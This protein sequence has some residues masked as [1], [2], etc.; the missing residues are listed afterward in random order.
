MR[1]EGRLTQAE[2]RKLGRQI[3]AAL[4]ADRIQ[5]ARQ[6]GKQAVMHL[7]AGRVREAW[8]TIWGWHKQVDPKA[9]KPCFQR[10][11]NQ[12]KEREA[13][14]GKVESPG[15]I[16]HPLDSR[17]AMYVLTIRIHERQVILYLSIY[18]VSL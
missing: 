1:Q 16:V 13:L 3:K 15:V 9:A 4:E 14:Y 18:T 17:N 7:K 11:E 12:T 2:G 8:G 10:L 5:R 6:V